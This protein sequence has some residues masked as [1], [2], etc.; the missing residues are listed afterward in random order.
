MSVNSYE[1]QFLS[2][3]FARLIEKYKAEKSPVCS[4][5]LVLASY[6]FLDDLEK[7]QQIFREYKLD[8]STEALFFLSLGYVRTSQYEKAQTILLSLLKNI[9]KPQDRFYVYQGIGFYR[10]FCSRYSKALRWAERAQK[11]SSTPYQKLINLDLLSQTLIR[12][13]KIQRGFLLSE[14]ALQIANE[15]NNKSAADAIQVS[16]AIHQSQFSPQTNETLARV[17]TL[18]SRFQSKNTYYFMNLTLEYVRRLNLAGQIEKSEAE[19]ELI[20]KEIFE[21]SLAR[22]KSLWSFRKA[23]VFFLK[24][25]MQLAYDM[26][27]SAT[28]FINPE[29]DLYLSVQI[30]GLRYKI[31]KI[32]NKTADLEIFEIEEKIKK[33]TFLSQDAMALS[34]AYRYAWL[35]KPITEDPFASFFHQWLR[36]GYKNYSLLKKVTNKKWISLLVD[37]IATQKNHFIYLDILPKNILLFSSSEIQLRSGL[38]PLIRQSLL[39]LSKGTYSKQKFVELIWGY[40]YDSYRHDPLVYTLLSRL[41]EVLGS[42]SENLIVNDNQILLRN[43][44]VRVY[45]HLQ[46]PK[47]IEKSEFFLEEQSPSINQRQLEILEY[48][49][50]NKYINVSQATEFLQVSQITACRDLKSLVLGKKIRKMGQGRATSYSLN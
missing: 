49:S 32:E 23:H 27:L 41:R 43:V 18:K 12:L 35:K 2:G 24:R 28:D 33:M 50:K 36:E 3:Q 26:T 39:L 34:Y 19:L 7:A 42:L 40:Q 37:L 48:L 6:I 46:I 25:E 20:K 14:K 11:T 31:L 45:E 5:V 47:M 8:Q 16:T 38:T 13:G 29:V 17:L 22:Q 9:N 10:Y 15:L 44:E 30:L 4:P 21:S 1:N